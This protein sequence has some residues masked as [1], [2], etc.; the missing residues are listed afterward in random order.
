MLIDGIQRGSSYEYFNGSG[1][2]SFI[3]WSR[4]RLAGKYIVLNSQ[5]G[6]AQAADTQ[7]VSAICETP[8]AG[9]FIIYKH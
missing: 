7:Y 5:I 1:I 3:P 4:K 9:K 2:I 6:G 8:A